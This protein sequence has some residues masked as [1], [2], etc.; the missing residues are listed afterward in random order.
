MDPRKL[1]RQLYIGIALYGAVFMILGVIFLRPAWLYALSLV[2]GLIAACFMAYNMYDVL[3]RALEL[4]AHSAKGFVTIRS[5]ARLMVCLVLM[6]VGIKLD[7]VSFVGVTVGLLG[8]KVSA[9]INPLVR[10]LLHEQIVTPESAMKPAEDDE[11]D[12]ADD[13]EDDIV[14]KYFG[15]YK[16]NVKNRYKSN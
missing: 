6:I 11:D 9:F 2:A 10:V 4:E 14:E 1:L 8:L 7:W 3:D 15:R 5:M 16:D 12:E 13:Y